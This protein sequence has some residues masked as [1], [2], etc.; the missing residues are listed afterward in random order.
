MRALLLSGSLFA[1]MAACGSPV[2]DVDVD[3]T[4]SSSDALT[5][6]VANLPA[7]REQHAAAKLA[8]GRVLIVGGNLSVGG[9]ATASTTIYD[10]STNS[11]SAGPTMTRAHQ[12]PVALTLPTGP[13]LVFGDGHTSVELIDVTTGF[14]SSTGSLPETLGYPAAVRLATGDV[15]A[16]GAR[17]TPSPAMVA[18][19]YVVAS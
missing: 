14:S 12:A 7:A 9:S 19:K 16:I 1:V 18:F 6:R 5:Y 3:P 17:Y 13:V 2:A 11:W 8:D 15:L 4:A 10:A